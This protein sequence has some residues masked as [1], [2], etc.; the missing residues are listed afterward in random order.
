M[1]DYKG[2]SLFND[3]KN[4]K[5]QDWNRYFTFYNI[6]QDKGMAKAKE[7]LTYIDKSGKERLVALH[8]RF[9]AGETMADIRRE[10]NA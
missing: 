2:Y 9:V 1:N 6:I 3:V 4:N 8:K 10:L 7:Y 5:L